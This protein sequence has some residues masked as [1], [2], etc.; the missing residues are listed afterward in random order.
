MVVF[1]LQRGTFVK[2]V[3]FQH[4]L[5]GQF[6]FKKNVPAPA[7]AS[8]QVNYSECLLIYYKDNSFVVLDQLSK[9]VLAFQKGLGTAVNQVEWLPL[10]NSECFFMK[11]SD[12]VVSYTKNQLTQKW[13]FMIL[14]GQASSMSCMSIDP[15]LTSLSIADSSTKILTS[16]DLRKF[17]K[18]QEYKLTGDISEI[19]QRED[20]LITIV[21]G[22]TVSLCRETGG[23]IKSL[24]EFPTKEALSIPQRVEIVYDQAA[25]ITKFQFL[26]LARNDMVEFIEVSITS[27]G[28]TG[29]IKQFYRVEGKIRAY[30]MHPS[31]EYVIILSDAGFYYIFNSEKGDIRGKHIVDASS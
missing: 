21:S 20:G 9:S 30:R 22:T 8:L 18:L 29:V 3:P 2:Q 25:D 7:V 24:I 23:E 13:E 10:L 4:K 6:N 26:M 28:A 31:N 17:N 16:Y 19:K 5:F 14:D 27:Q 12:Q 15:S 1:E 11:T